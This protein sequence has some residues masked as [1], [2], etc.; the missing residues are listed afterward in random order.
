MSPSI[1]GRPFDAVVWDYDGTLVDTRSTDEAAV[2]HIVAADAGAAEGAALFWST[3]GR[4]ILERI[5]RA[6]PGRTADF[7]PHFDGDEPP[8]I[9]AGV[10]PLLRELRRRDMPLAIVSSRRLQPL[11]RGLAS[12]RLRPFFDVV[13]GLDTVHMPKPDPEGLLLALERLGVP[14]TRAVVVGDRD[15]DLEAARRAGATGWRA[16]WSLGPLGPADRLP[17]DLARPASVLERLDGPAAAAG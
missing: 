6:W 15:V 3:E 4:P 1:L 14:P 11:L 10:R 8:R 9:F 2:R 17:V 7:L 12:S 16:A 5:E 13:I